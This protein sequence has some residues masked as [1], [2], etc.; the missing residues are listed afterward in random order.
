[1]TTNNDHNRTND[2]THERTRVA[3]VNDYELVVH[4][5]EGMLRPFRD[6]INVVEL[7]IDHA[8]DCNVDV[9]LFD[10]D[11]ED[12]ALHRVTSLAHNPH[13]RAVAIYTWSVTN[14]QLEA[15]VAAGARG[16]LSK[17]LPAD[18]LVA[19]IETVAN[20]KFVGPAHD[21]GAAPRWP[22]R[23]LGFTARESEVAMLL[24]E[25]LK[26]RDI[27]HALWVS[28]NTV[29]THLKTIFRKMDVTSRGQVIAI[30]SVDPAFRR[31]NVTPLKRMA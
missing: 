14:E 16:V 30:L 8:P 24:A 7:D 3:L 21:V 15:A 6:R 12:L 28:E 5:L 9:A 18:E 31:W 4:G 2:S 27:A 22:G 23:N 25:G 1:M 19:A 11:D 26:N 20:G 10:T 29:K 13:V 17:S